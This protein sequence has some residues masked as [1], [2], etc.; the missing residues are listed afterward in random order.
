MSLST[1]ERVRHLVAAA[2]RK[3]GAGWAHLSDEQRRGAIALEV[4]AALL[5]QDEASAP[6]ALVR[7]Q[8]L[9]EG[10]LALA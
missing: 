8:A 7:L 6:P 2:R 5:A 1:E 4:V 3:Y 10:A 9:A